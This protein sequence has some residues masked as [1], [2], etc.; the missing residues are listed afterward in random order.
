VD[1]AAGDGHEADPARL[2]RVGDVVDAEAGRPVALPAGDGVRGADLLAE[3]SLVIFALVLELGG[4]EHV[5]GMDDE[6]QVAMRLQMD[7]P[8]VGRRRHIGHRLRRSR[9]ANVDDAEPL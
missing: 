6:Q 1:A 9:V 3:R 7:V 4:G 5:L 2:G 8:G